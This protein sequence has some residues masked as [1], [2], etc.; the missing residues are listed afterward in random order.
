MV[1]YRILLFLAC[2]AIGTLSR[3]NEFKIESLDSNGTLIFQ[4]LE[5][6]TGYQVEWASSPSGPWHNTWESL[7]YIQS[8]GALSVTS[9]IP[10]FYRVIAK[11]VP[12]GM[13]RIPEGENSGYDTDFGQ[14]SIATESFFMDE[15]EVTEE[16]W[17]VVYNWAIS[18]NYVLATGEGKAP[19]HPVYSVSE[20]N[21]MKWC[22]ARSEMDGRQPC[23][24]D[25]AGNRKG[26]SP[27]I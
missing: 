21:C 19:N 11:P 1:K 7:T 15:T 23:Y 9:N 10:M 6:S 4:E 26:V 12:D 17:D 16:Q 18:N 13:V 20:H 22:N 2:F 27:V 25:L 5:G 3:A 24:R 14:Y 8:E